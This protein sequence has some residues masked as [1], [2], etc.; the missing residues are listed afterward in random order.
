ML[1]CLLAM[2]LPLMILRRVNLIWSSNL[3]LLLLLHPPNLQHLNRFLL[4]NR[5]RRSLNSLKFLPSHS[6]NNP[7]QASTRSLS[8]RPRQMPNS[9]QMTSMLLMRMSPMFTKE[10]T[11]M[12]KKKLRPSLVSW[13]PLYPHYSNLR[14]D[15][16]QRNHLLPNNNLQL[17]RNSLRSNSNLVH[18]FNHRLKLRCQI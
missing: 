16:I 2:E 8:S 15:K 14:Q 7:P 5:I 3:Y 18:L 9:S 11:T 17:L 10:A 12:R 4:H 6:L 1:W 13:N